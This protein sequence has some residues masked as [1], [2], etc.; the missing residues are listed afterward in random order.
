MSQEIKVGIIGSANERHCQYLAA[1]LKY[2]GAV[3]VL[4]DNAPV[5]DFPLTMRIGN[6]GYDA[7]CYRK[8]ITDVSVLYLR[9]LFLPSPAI[10]TSTIQEQLRRDGYAAYAGERER[11]AT[12]L[13][14]LQALPLDNKLLVNPV[15]TLLL[16]FTKPFQLEKLR[17]LGI[18]IPETLVTGSAEDLLEFADQREVVY[19]PVAGGALCRILKE[20][21]K[22][23]DKLETLANAP[24][25][26]QEYVPGDDIRVFV[27][28]DSVIASFEIE[29]EGVDYRESTKRVKAVT[30]PDAVQNMCI[31]ACRDL[32]LIF[33]GVDLKRCGA[34]QYVMIECNPSPMFEGFDRAAPVPIVRHLAEF[35]IKEAAK[36]LDQAFV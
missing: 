11:Y 19:K 8:P 28:N 1:E 4:L 27:L 18:P 34:G 15:D 2:Q 6:N 33:S 35:L 30:I 17:R 32:G 3:P 29:G 23:P 10:D 14:W 13:S 31:R 36:R 16:H 24:V 22:E 20:E 25:L 7:A 12:W 26:F 9:A 21:D 5:L